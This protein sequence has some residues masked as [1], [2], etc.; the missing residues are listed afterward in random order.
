MTATDVQELKK[1]IES[2]E[3]LVKRQN[4]LIGKTGQSMMEL[5]VSRQRSDLANFQTSKGSSLDTGDVATNNDLVQLVAE[6]QGELNNMEERSIRRLANTSKT[7]PDDNIAPLLNGDGDIPNVKDSW[8][9]KTIKEFETL[10]DVALFRLAK[11][12]E[13]VPLSGKE[14]EK[15]EQYLDGKIENMQITDSSDEDIAKE[16]TNYSADQIDDIYND[17]ARYLGLSTRRGVHEW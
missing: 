1:R 3:T 8:F 17:V 10:T 6:L 15:Y 12:Y 7:K 2:L 16:V 13:R 9:P 4:L 5:Q 11:F 14:Q